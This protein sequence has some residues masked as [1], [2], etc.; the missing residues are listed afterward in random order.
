MLAKA[1]I[2]ILGLQ[3]VGPRNGTKN[4]ERDQFRSGKL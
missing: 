4:V 3:V 2:I 1:D